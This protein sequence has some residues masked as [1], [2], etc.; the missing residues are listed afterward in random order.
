MIEL[1]L[2]AYN[3]VFDLFLVQGFICL[4]NIVLQ[5]AAVTWHI[6]ASLGE[7]TD[8][9]QMLKEQQ[10]TQLLVGSY[11]SVRTTLGKSHILRCLCTWYIKGILVTCMESH[12]AKQLIGGKNSIPSHICILW[13]RIYMLWTTTVWS[14]TQNWLKTISCV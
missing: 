6:N 7:W 4:R 11:I 1:L 2:R 12:K 9:S 8:K 14:F 3:D 13:N 5:T 10:K